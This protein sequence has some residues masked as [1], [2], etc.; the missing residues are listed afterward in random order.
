MSATARHAKVPTVMPMMAAT[1]MAV[2]E[3]LPVFGAADGEVDGV[4]VIVEVVK[5]VPK[6][7]TWMS[8]LVPDWLG[9]E[10]KVA[11]CGGSVGCIVSLQPK[12]L[13]GLAVMSCLGRWGAMHMVSGKG[14]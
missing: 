14:V 3:L 5:T 11:D 1:G 8:D 13:L 7:G 6:V 2:V 12:I 10:I 9:S 4:R